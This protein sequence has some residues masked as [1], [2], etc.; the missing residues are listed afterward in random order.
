MV[1]TPLW[2]P[3]RERIDAANVT[4]FARRIESKHRVSLPD[5]D[6][7]WRW[8]IEHPSSSGARCGT[9]AG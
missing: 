3:S 6:S 7:L 9:T 1:A 4:A 5:Y 2:T 8:S